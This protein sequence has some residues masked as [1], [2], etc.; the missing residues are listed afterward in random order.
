M[1]ITHYNTCYVIKNDYTTKNLKSKTVFNLKQYCM[2]CYVTLSNV[3]QL[4]G[5]DDTC[6]IN[7][8]RFQNQFD[9]IPSALKLVS[10]YYR[11]DS[12]YFCD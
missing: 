2:H 6:K 5:V 1:I 9:T 10:K 3:F 11:Y 8:I 7:L 4:I 12:E